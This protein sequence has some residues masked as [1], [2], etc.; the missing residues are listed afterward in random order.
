MPRAKTSSTT[1]KSSSKSTTKKITRKKPIKKKAKPVIIDVI[2]DEDLKN[3]DLFPEL[4]PIDKLVSLEDKF[5]DKQANQLSKDNKDIDQQKKFF[6]ELVTEIKE[7]KRPINRFAQVDQE[8]NGR[9]KR[10]VSL[11]RRLVWKFLVLVGLLIIVVSYFSFSQLTIVISPRGETLSETLFL[12]VSSGTNQE[13]SLNDLEEKSISGE[14]QEV[15][16]VVEKTYQSTGEEFM[17]ED[18]VGQVKIINNYS[19]DQPLVTNTRLLSPDNKLY[20]I[21]NAVNVPAGGQVEVAIYTEKPTEDMAIGPT[22][23]TIPGL[24]LGLQDKIYAR[25]DTEFTFKQKIQKYVKQ[26]DLERVRLELNDLLLQTAKEDIVSNLG[27]DQD[28]LYQ[29]IEPATI[30]IEAKA[31]E[32]KDEFVAKAKG[33]I[34]AVTFSKEEAVKLAAARL[35]L[36]IP[37]DKELIEFN[38]DN[39]SYSLENYDADNH[40]ATIKTFFTAT[41]SLR[42]DSEIID[43]SQ[44]VNLTAEQI[45]TYLHDFP[46]IKDYELKFSPSFIKKAPGLVDRIKIKIKTID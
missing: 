2:S 29:S 19:K 33:K 3:E 18:I 21:K 22:T 28:W 38:P 36:L 37:D 40:T 41:M 20:R 31:N 42:N 26:S 6:S 27:K 12:K 5:E 35:N 8:E 14:I 9:V 4:P 46:E 23:F 24:W 11:Y 44:L 13:T 7:K 25:S 17:G 39:I 32:Q 45:D 34:V 10:N 1:K 15:E 30:E 16:S 43:R